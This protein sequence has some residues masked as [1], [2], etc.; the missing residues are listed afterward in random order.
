MLGRNLKRIWREGGKKHGVSLRK[1]AASQAREGHEV[2]LA[3]QAWL[4]R[5]AA[6]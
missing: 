2:G 5:K 1:W 4:Q 6:V 3:C